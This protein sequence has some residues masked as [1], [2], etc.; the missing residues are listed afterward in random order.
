MSYSQLRPVRRQRF[1]LCSLR[2]RYADPGHG[3]WCEHIAIL[4][5]TGSG[6]SWL[7]R[8]ER[9]AYDG[10]LPDCAAPTGRDDG[11]DCGSV[12]QQMEADEPSLYRFLAGQEKRAVI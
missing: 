5:T 12:C 8:P 6:K 9:P 10:A 1:S 2:R 11:R 7:L 3:D 4:G